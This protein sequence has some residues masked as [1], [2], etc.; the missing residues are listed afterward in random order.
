MPT[1]QN[2]IP[3]AFDPRQVECLI[4]GVEPYDFAPDTK[5]VINKTEDL[6]IPQSGV[7][8]AAAFSINT[9]TLGTIT[10]SLK[11][12]SKFNET[13][14]IWLAE[15]TKLEADL[16]YFFPFYLRDPSSGIG[17]ETYGWVQSQPDFTLGN[18]VG[19]LDWVIGLSDCRFKMFDGQSGVE[20]IAAVTL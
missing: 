20:G 11:N 2:P 7:D 15:L 5:M 10:L 6:I 17:I 9:N 4:G 12:T 18:E 3:T 8:G 16:V 13:L 1:I 19:Q 14:M